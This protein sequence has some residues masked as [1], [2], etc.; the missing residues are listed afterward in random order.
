MPWYGGQLD[1]GFGVGVG[2][3][4]GG[5]VG[6]ADGTARGRVAECGET[7]A[8]VTVGAREGGGGAACGGGVTTAATDGG[9]EAVFMAGAIET[10]PVRSVTSSPAIATSVKAPAAANSKP[11]RR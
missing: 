4:G 2:C 3:G 9:G 1:A 5:G 11:G 7:C 10:L 6:V 8:V